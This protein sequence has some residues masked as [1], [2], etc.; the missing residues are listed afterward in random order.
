MIT[1]SSISSRYSF[2][3]YYN[4]EKIAIGYVGSTPLSNNAYVAMR[5]KDIIAMGNDKEAFIA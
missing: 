1:F 5:N 2:L 4:Y 3:I